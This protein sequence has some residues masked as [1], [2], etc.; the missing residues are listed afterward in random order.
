MGKR[1]LNVMGLSYS[2][3]NDGSCIVVLSDRHSRLKLPVIVKPTEA[4]RIVLEVEKIDS[5]RPMVYDVMKQMT[6][7]YNID[8]KEVFIHSILSG[9]YYTKIVTTNGVE[10]LDFECSTGDAIS[11]ALIYKVPIFASNEVLK[12]AAIVTDENGQVIPDNDLTELED[13][14][15]DEKIATPITSVN[16]LEKMMQDAIKNEEYETAAKLRDKIDEMK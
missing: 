8:V 5:P 14:S 16:D 7:V 1:E 15:D 2:Q 9:V 10:D 12:S 6:D 11:L 4:T 3:S 13:F